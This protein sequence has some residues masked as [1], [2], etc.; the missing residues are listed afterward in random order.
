MDH[1]LRLDYYLDLIQIH[2]EKPFCLHNFQALIYQGSG[3]NGDLMAHSPVGMLQSVLHP[4]M[5]QIFP[6]LSTERPSGSGNQK[7]PDTSGSFSVKALVNGA[8]FTVHRVDLYALFLCQRHDNMSGGYQGLFIGQSNIFSRADGFNGRT[9]SDHSHNGRHKDLCLLH[10][11][12]LDQALHA[13]CYFTACIFH[14]DFQFFCQSRGAHCRKLWPEGADLLFQ[15]IDIFSGSQAYHLK[16]FIL[17][18]N[19]QSLGSDRAGRAQYCDHCHNF[20][21]FIYSTKCETICLVSLKSHII[22][23]H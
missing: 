10:N 18:Y 23:V 13:P 2:P 8:V 14:P 19:I 20:I 11:C 7:F 12:Q 4:D 3:I 5:F 21:P 16:I 15:Q 22:S 9:D 1:T 17:T 6:F